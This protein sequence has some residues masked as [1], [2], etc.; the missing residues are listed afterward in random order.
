MWSKLN[1][2]FSGPHEARQYFENI[3]R[4]CLPNVRFKIFNMYYEDVSKT[5]FESLFVITPSEDEEE[6]FLLID[7][8]SGVVKSDKQAITNMMKLGW[9][10]TSN[11]LNDVLGYDPYGGLKMTM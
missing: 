6:I 11:S 10:T 4:I 5:D 2:S 1:K 7:N 3:L 9:V 8:R